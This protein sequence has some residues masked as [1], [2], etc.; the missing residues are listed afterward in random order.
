MTKK[1][2]GLAA[3]VGAFIL[4]IAV[5]RANTTSPLRPPAAAAAV[6][7]TQTSPQ[8]ASPAPVSSGAEIKRSSQM[9][10]DISTPGRILGIG[11]IFFKSAD[12][13]AL[14]SWYK[15]ALGLPSGPEGTTFHWRELASP[16][17]EHMTVWATFPNKT[18]YFDPSPAPFMIN[19]IVDDLGAFLKKCAAE[20]VK[21]DPKRD[22]ASYGRFAW[23]YDPD[24]NKIELWQPL[25]K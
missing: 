24:G 2:L 6:N 3:I 15:N 23:I 25:G 1:W 11:G 19:Y 20:G 12:D 13:K 8:S 16:N 18:K 9:A 7:L 10:F 14:S 22:D 17:T 4:W 5:S 21:I